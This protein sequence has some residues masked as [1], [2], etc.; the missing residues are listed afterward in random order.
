MPRCRAGAIINIIGPDFGEEGA[1]NLE[2]AGFGKLLAQLMAL[3]MAYWGI[4]GR[5]PEVSLRQI[6]EGVANPGFLL[7]GAVE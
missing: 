6:R 7:P 4:Y 2:R 5:E 3:S 1:T